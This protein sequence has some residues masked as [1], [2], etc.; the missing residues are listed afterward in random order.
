M[1]EP[2][3]DRRLDDAPSK[4]PGRIAAV[5]GFVLG[6][7]VGWLVWARLVVPALSGDPTPEN[8]SGQPADWIHYV[9]LALCVAVSLFV[10]SVIGEW[11]GSRR[12]RRSAG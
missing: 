7:G 9:S 12:R 2:H 1:F 5:L 3:D 11:I 8:P 10:V 6:F 4:A